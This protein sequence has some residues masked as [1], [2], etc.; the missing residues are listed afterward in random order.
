MDGIS[1]AYSDVPLELIERHSL[2]RRTHDRGGEREIRFLRRARNP[3][4]PVWYCGQM[5]IATWG[6]RRGPLPRSP[7]TW[8]K[9]LDEGQWAPYQPERIEIPATLGLQ[10]G[11]WFRVRGRIQGLLVGGETV[12]MLIEPASYYY[13]IMT[14]CEWMPVLAGERI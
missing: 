4:L 6:C 5:R 12:Y 7:L 9:T 3:L 13:R 14:R 1:L 11:I 2:H 8:Q 10:G